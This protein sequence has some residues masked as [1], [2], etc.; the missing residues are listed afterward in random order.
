MALRSTIRPR[1]VPAATSVDTILTELRRLGRRDRREVAA[2]YFPSAMTTFGVAAPDLRRLARASARELR[3]APAA[4]V[5]RLARGLVAARNT[6]A[7]TCAYE[8]LSRHPAAMAALDERGVTALGRGNDNWGS[9]DAF[10]VLVAGAAWRAGRISDD[11]IAR[12]AASK[13]RWWRRTALVATVPL[14]ARSRGGRGDVL[15]TLLVCERLVGDRDDMV[16][17]ALSWALRELAKHE[18]AAVRAFLERHKGALAPR[19]VREVTNK[20]RTGR[21]NPRAAR[22]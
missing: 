17:K 15:R 21:K 2:W 7:R 10:A 5:L 12:W 14:N 20:L 13:D 4:R 3:L 16:V 22:R 1:P 19:V 18:A 8:I 6:D 11:V 9:V